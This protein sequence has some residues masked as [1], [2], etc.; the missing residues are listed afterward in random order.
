MDLVEVGP[1]CPIDQATNPTPADG[2]TGVDVNL[3][4]IDW[5]NGA[6]ADSVEVWFDGVMVYNGTAIS[7]WPIA[8]P[9]AYSTTYPW[10]IVGKNDTCS[11]GGPTWSFRTGADPN[12][13]CVFMDDF[14]AGAG[15]WVI[16]NDGGTCV[17]E[18]WDISTNAYTMPPEAMLNVL[19]ADADVCDL[20][21]TTLSTTT[22]NFGVDA[23][24]WEFVWIEFDNDFRTFAGNDASWVE[25]SLDGGATW[26]E[27]ASWIG[28]D[29]RNTHEVW[30]V[31]DT[32]GLQ[33]DI[34]FRLRSIQPGW[35]WWWAVDNFA[36]YFDGFIPVELTS[37]AASVSDG[38][39]TLNWST[40]TETN[41]QG[42]DVERN[43]G[44]GFEK[45]GY[46]AGIGTSTEIHNY[47]YVD[48]SLQ[49]GTYTYRLKQI[50]YD[51]TSEYSEI[52]EVDVIAPDVFA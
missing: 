19:A 47:S 40:S 33:S 7:T 26:T 4:S 48:G 3:A 6:G 24:D 12:I 20:G 10:Q 15:N 52:V 23:T 1:P 46:V 38:N 2:A 27:V 29:N 39:V 14:E 35:N 50:D 41:N 8:G 5:T 30:D 21:T 11:V 45:I 31:S 42:F 34:R 28:V 32:A 18:V 9:L 13:L 25:M 43:S 51:G 36:I 37:F 16:T 22:M 49:E 17:W 44:N